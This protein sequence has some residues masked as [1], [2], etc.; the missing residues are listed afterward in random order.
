MPKRKT[1]LPVEISYKTKGKSL[2]STADYIISSA[3][4]VISSADYMI[5]SVD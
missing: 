5:S 1:G 4:Y 2:I 3:D